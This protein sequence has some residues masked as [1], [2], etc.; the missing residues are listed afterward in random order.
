[1]NR[2]LASLLLLLGASLVVSGIARGQTYSSYVTGTQIHA[3]ANH[4]GNSQSHLLI[5][6]VTITVPTTVSRASWTAANAYTRNLSMINIYDA[7]LHCLTSPGPELGGCEP[8]ML[9]THTGP[10]LSWQTNPQANQQVSVPLVADQN[11]VCRSYPCNLPVG[12]YS[13]TTASSESGTNTMSLWADGSSLDKGGAEFH[14]GNSFVIA[15]S[16]DDVMIAGYAS[17]EPQI[18]FSGGNTQVA[19]PVT[20]LDGQSVSDSETGFAPGMRI[21]VAGM[22]S[23]TGG[24]NDPCNGYHLVDSVSS[25][26]ITYTIAGTYQCTLE[27]KADGSETCNGLPAAKGAQ[28]YACIGAGLPP[29]FGKLIADQQNPDGEFNGYYCF[30][31]GA[32]WGCRRDS[33]VGPAG[34][35]SGAHSVGIMIY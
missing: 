32:S 34:P 25:T 14:I 24:P 16:P 4:W 17:E 3:M 12:T 11:T 23:G 1:M 29:M 30:V 6:T 28:G 9:Y 15:A 10:L 22:T 35:Q 20:M 26:A 33:F 21:L 2:Q 27:G 31:G 8:G 7:G 5:D 13:L 18:T 19:V